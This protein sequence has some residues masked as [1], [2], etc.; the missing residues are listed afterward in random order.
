ML[1]AAT[2]LTEQV[3]PRAVEG[4]AGL[5]PKLFTARA[6]GGALLLDSC[7]REAQRLLGPATRDPLERFPR[8]DRAALRLLLLSARENGRGVVARIAARGQCGHAELELTLAPLLRR[9]DG[10]EA[11]L[12]LLQ[13]LGGAAPKGADR[14]RVLALH[15][16]PAPARRLQ[17][18]GSTIR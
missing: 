10:S 18:V 9:S 15:Q 7:G 17:L 11:V 3:D 12:G 4:F 2:R 5:I 6:Q 8:S 16:V 1:A 13:P 14:L